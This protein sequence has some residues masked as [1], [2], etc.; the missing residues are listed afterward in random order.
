[1]RGLFVYLCNIYHPQS[2]HLGSI[3]T[4]G[5]NVKTS[6]RLLKAPKFIDGTQSSIGKCQYISRESRVSCPLVSGEWCLL[7]RTAQV[8]G[9][10]SPLDWARKCKCSGQLRRRRRNDVSNCGN[11]FCCCQHSRAES[12][13]NL[14]AVL[15]LRRIKN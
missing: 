2:L 5:R 1:M 11:C 10:V 4:V 14:F 15:F 6:T 8:D 9:G 3:F 12:T 7:G 13:V